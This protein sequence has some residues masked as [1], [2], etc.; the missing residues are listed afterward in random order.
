MLVTITGST[1]GIGH[2]LALHLAKIGHQVV[3]FSRSQGFDI[4]SKST[5]DKILPTIKRS[6]IFI[7]NAYHETGQTELLNEM[8]TAWTGTTKTLV[9]IGS[10]CA[11]V[12]EQ[13]F[14]DIFGDTVYNQRYIN[15]KKTQLE[16]INRHLENNNQRVLHVMPAMVNTEMLLESLRSPN[17]MA[18]ADVAELICNT[19]FSQRD[20]LYIQQLTFTSI[21]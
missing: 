6:D 20:T 8:L 18:P 16:I 4:G 7:N 13:K 19:I 21:V 15:E 14:L 12:S 5:R 1:K 17:N 2:A 10:S 9:H 11:N 3:G